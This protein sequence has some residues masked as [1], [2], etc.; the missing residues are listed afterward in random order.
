MSTPLNL[1][2]ISAYNQIRAVFW[3]NFSGILGD[4]LLRIRVGC[5]FCTLYVSP[6]LQW[7]FII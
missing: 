6:S 4:S 3:A 5:G 7:E 1:I 2:R